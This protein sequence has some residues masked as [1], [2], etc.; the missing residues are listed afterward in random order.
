M[1]N[2]FYQRYRYL[3]LG[4]A[5]CL[6]PLVALGAVRAMGTNANDVRTWL[7][8]GLAEAQEYAWFG[9]HF[10]TEEFVAVSWEGCTIDDPRLPR[11]ADVLA[12]PAGGASP[13]GHLPLVEAVLTGPQALDELKGPACA[14]SPSG[15]TDG[16]RAQWCGRPTRAGMIRTDCWKRFTAPPSNAASP[17]T[18]CEW[19][20][21]S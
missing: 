19:E 4:A 9:Q 16:I 2:S 20:G 11:L 6:A 13:S 8:Q 10:G 15:L 21:R 17:A 14:V 3:L 1:N 12:P 7:P 18:R 5:V